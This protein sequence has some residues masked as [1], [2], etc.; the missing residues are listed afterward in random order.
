MAISQVV[1]GKCWPS[2]GVGTVTTMADP[3]GVCIARS[4]IVGLWQRRSKHSCRKAEKK[5]QRYFHY[6]VTEYHNDFVSD[7]ELSEEPGTR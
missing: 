5:L 4:K 1:S 3:G 7:G 2:K 6:S